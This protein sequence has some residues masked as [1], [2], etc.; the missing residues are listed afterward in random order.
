MRKKKYP[1]ISNNIQRGFELIYACLYADFFLLT[2]KILCIPRKFG[3]T[4]KLKSK[5]IVRIMEFNEIY[6]FYAM[7]K[8]KKMYLLN[9]WVIWLFCLVKKN[10]IYGASVVCIECYMKDFSWLPTVSWQNV[11]FMSAIKQLLF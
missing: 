10:K 11:F 6:L 9:F 1:S 3:E 7:K 5:Y 2:W 4:L 8:K